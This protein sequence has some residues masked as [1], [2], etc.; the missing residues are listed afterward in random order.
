ML[1][2]L[3]FSESAVGAGTF[4]FVSLTRSV[5]EKANQAVRETKTNFNNILLAVTNT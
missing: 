4:T 1:Y 3:C 5:V 2:Q